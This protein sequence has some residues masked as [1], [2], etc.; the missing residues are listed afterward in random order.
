MPPPPPPPPPPPRAPAKAGI[1]AG[2]RG[3]DFGHA[4]VEYCSSLYIYKYI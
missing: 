1:L 2:T 4:L 3:N